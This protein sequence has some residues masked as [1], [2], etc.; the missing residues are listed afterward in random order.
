MAQSFVAKAMAKGLGQ[1]AALIHSSLTNEQQHKDDNEDHKEGVT[2]GHYQLHQA[3]LENLLPSAKKTKETGTVE[4][5][6]TWDPSLENRNSVLQ[7]SPMV[8]Y[9][10]PTQPQPPAFFQFMTSTQECFF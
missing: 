1:V 6:H 8:E 9:P 5:E 3:G 10:I 2:I 4:K 7:S